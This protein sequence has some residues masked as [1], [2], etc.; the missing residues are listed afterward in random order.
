MTDDEGG[1]TLRLRPGEYEFAIEPPFGAAHLPGR[2]SIQVGH[3]DVRGYTACR[4]EPAAIV[5]MEARDA[6]TGAGIE[7]V[8]F[9][10]ETDSDSRRRELRS[11]LVIVD[12]PRDRRA[13][14]IAGDRRAGAEAVL[15]RDDPAGLEIRGLARARRSSSWPGGR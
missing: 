5:T 1:T 6:K 10:Y 15:R 9:Q 8:R 11:Q 2:G 14:P 7:G 3:E 4:L 13:G 12:H